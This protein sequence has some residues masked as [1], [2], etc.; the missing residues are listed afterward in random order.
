MEWESDTENG[1]VHEIC[2]STL[3]FLIIRSRADTVTDV[4]IGR[5]SGTCESVNLRS[6][7]RDREGSV[8]PEP[9]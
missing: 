5:T 2:E 6:R 7:V 3:K 8:R 4:Q 1:E 9:T